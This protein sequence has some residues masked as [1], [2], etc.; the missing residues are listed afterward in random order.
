[1]KCALEKNR[2]TA[3]MG[4]DAQNI[5]N[6]SVISNGTHGS[7]VNNSDNTKNSNKN[8]RCIP[9]R[10]FFE[11][12]KN[13]TMATPMSSSCE[14]QSNSEFW[15]VDFLKEIFLQ[16][17]EI[18][19][20]EKIILRKLLVDE[21]YSTNP[22]IVLSISRWKVIRV[23]KL[24]SCRDSI[25]NV[26]DNG[27]LARIFSVVTSVEVYDGYQNI[28]I[29]FYNEYAK[30]LHQQ[31]F[32]SNGGNNGKLNTNAS[33]CRSGSQTNAITTLLSFE[34]LPAYKCV[35]PYPPSKVVLGDCPY[36][37]C[38]GDISKARVNSSHKMRFDS[39]NFH[40]ELLSMATHVI[41]STTTTTK[42]TNNIKASAALGTKRIVRRNEGTATTTTTPAEGESDIQCFSRLHIYNEGGKHLQSTYTSNETN[43]ANNQS[44]VTTTVAM[45][46]KAERSKKTVINSTTK[47]KKYTYLTLVRK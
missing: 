8:D 27:P 38:I 1:M 5:A 40:L 25:K 36:C 28:L 37:I 14:R 44:T 30:L 32:P 42:V 47:N 35:I 18:N 7:S 31:L 20:K 46:Q 26:S 22:N 6:Y 39:R 2:L 24:R 41:T 13:T 29:F 16:E 23:W 3:T 4:D 45:N 21:P 10:D 33:L 11:S 19:E 15:L 9:Y 17:E 43:T 34:E 12:F